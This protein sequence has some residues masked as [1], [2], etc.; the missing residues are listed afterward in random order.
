MSLHS[1]TTN[2]IL[3]CS[4]L[5]S[6]FTYA[7]LTW[8]FKT[9]GEITGQPIIH[10]SLIYVLSGQSLTVLDKKGDIQ[11]QYNTKANTYS[12]VAIFNRSIYLLADNGL[13]ALN[14]DGS[15]KWFFQN[16]DT[17]LIVEGKTMGWGEGKF[18][19]PWSWYRSSPII[20]NEKV[21][22]G[23][24]N[25]TFAIS[26]QTG[27]QI[28]HTDTGI[29]HTKP[30]FHDG[31]VV[32]GSWDN[33]LYGLNVE[34]G[35]VT[36]QFASRTP[37]GAMAGWDGWL[38]FN[39]SP[40][41]HNGIVYV[42]SRGSYFYA[43]DATNGIEKWSSQYASTWIGSPAI[44]SNGQ[45]YFGTSDGYSLI[46]LNADTGSQ[47]LL[48]LNEF[49]NFAQPQADDK[50]IYFASV[51]GELYSV[52][53]KTSQK[54]LLFS[55]PKSQK[56]SGD[57]V[58]KGGG[59]KRLFSLGDDYNHANATRDVKRMKDK[60]DSILSLTI[61]EGTLY[62]GSANGNIYAVTL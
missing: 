27:Q 12:S 23:N 35:I 38:G 40:I 37:Q 17:P 49:Y 52:N 8:Q 48:Q 4:I 1:I 46:G 44:E 20:V 41:I 30:A 51:A 58:K 59:L 36:W 26:A 15:E 57:L 24:A 60:L 19:D 56:Y 43:I 50:N 3:L 53:K 28:W 34:D 55:T 29:T 6:T 39:L 31:T 2:F 22:F 42:G 45:I 32:I 33:H 61:D 21:I 25:G 16:Q 5:L 7:D 62:M 10:E 9:N 47:T 14:I 18:I 54:N 11:W 13:H